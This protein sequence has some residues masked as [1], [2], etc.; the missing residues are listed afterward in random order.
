MDCQYNVNE[1][2][3]FLRFQVKQMKDGIFL[4]QPKFVKELVKKFELENAKPAHTHMSTTIKL[5][6]DPFGKE[7]N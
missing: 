5:S 1:L 4:S 3:F 6:L 7:V 2:K